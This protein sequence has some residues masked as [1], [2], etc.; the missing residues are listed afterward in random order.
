MKFIGISRFEELLVD[1][2]GWTEEERKEAIEKATDKI[3][4]LVESI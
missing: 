2:T 1:R 3:E 4:K